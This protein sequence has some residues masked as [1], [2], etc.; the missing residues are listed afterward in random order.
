MGYAKV[1][2]FLIYLSLKKLKINL[3]LHM[4]GLPLLPTLFQTGVAERFVEKIVLN[5]SE[6]QT[7]LL[8]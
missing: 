8:S 2:P 1:L 7:S 5:M 6:I 4:F 3:I